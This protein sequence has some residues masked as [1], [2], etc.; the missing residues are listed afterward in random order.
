MA[1]ITPVILVFY[2]PP[3]CELSSEKRDIAY[4]HTLIVLSNTL[5]IEEKNKILLN[6][7]INKWS[8]IKEEYINI[9][10]MV[11]LTCVS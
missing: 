8:A 2:S 3:E 11:L 6:K 5:F 10:N 9:L 7:Y 1:C 4:C